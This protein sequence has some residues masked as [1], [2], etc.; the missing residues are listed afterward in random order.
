MELNQH[1]TLLAVLTLNLTHMVHTAHN[2]QHTANADDAQATQ[3][4][5]LSMCTVQP[6][7]PLH[8]AVPLMSASPA[9]W[10]RHVIVSFDMHNH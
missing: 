5:A 3:R 8:S 9:T 7:L 6:P 1:H 4:S 2:K 10:H